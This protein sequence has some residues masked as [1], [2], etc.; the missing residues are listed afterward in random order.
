MPFSLTLLTVFFPLVA[1]ITLCSLS[2]LANLV[3]PRLAPLRSKPRRS[4]H[5]PR[6]R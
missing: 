5:R 6:R 2:A 3:G 1:L 4:K